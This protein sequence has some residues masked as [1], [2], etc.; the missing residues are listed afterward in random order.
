MPKD[1]PQSQG[2]YQQAGTRIKVLFIPLSPSLPQHHPTNTSLRY[3][4]GSP[5]PKS[6]P[7]TPPGGTRGSLL[8]ECPRPAVG[9]A[10]CT[11][12]TTRCHR[13]CGA[14]NAHSGAIR[15]GAGAICGAGAIRGGAGVICSSQ[16][17]P[18]TERQPAQDTSLVA[19]ALH[20]AKLPVPCSHTAPSK[21]FS[22]SCT[23][24]CQP[25]AAPS[26]VFLLIIKPNCKRAREQCSTPPGP[27]ASP[28]P[29]RGQRGNEKEGK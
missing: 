23:A 22:S 20:P 11:G 6:L 28:T 16:S 12:D 13:C 10:P 1:A 2:R 15:G 5:A 19:L 29:G 18:W 27:L 25:P 14:L 24:P 26:R 21:T 4:H 8:A 7:C 17:C 9:T 3:K